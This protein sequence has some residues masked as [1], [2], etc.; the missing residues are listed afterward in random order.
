MSIV[1]RAAL[2]AMTAG[3]LMA[4]TGAATATV[5]AEPVKTPPP[6]TSIPAPA[7]GAAAGK[8]P[9]VTKA[10]GPLWS[11]SCA[12]TD[13]GAEICYVEQFAIAT[14]QNVMMLHVRV[15]YLGPD[16]KPRLILATPL[17]VLLQPGITLVVDQDKPL[18]LPFDACQQGG[19]V[20]AADLEDGKVLDHFTGGKVLAV[21]YINGDKAAVDIP[22]QLSGLAAAL[23]ALPTP[24]KRTP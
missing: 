22:V 13:A 7:N 5:A 16:G 14:P 20:A 23:K 11:K 1:A 2:V 18:S 9:D 24:P 4:Y 3:V 15:G 12:K 6:A 10:P 21:R 19:C 8:G 17:G